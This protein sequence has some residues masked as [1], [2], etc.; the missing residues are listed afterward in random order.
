MTLEQKDK[1][2]FGLKV[3][4]ICVPSF[5]ERERKQCKKALREM[6]GIKDPYLTLRK[7]VEEHSFGS[8]HRFYCKLPIENAVVD[9]SFQDIGTFIY[10]YGESHLDRFYVVDDKQES[11]GGDCTNYQCNHYLTLELKED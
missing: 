8:Y 5:D 1:Y 4:D 11:N 9:A 3:I 7:Y 6:L 2:E 10:S